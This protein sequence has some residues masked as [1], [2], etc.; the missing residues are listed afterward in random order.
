MLTSGRYCCYCTAHLRPYPTNHIF[1]F[2]PFAEPI[3]PNLALLLLLTAQLTEANA[4]TSHV[5]KDSGISSSIFKVW[6]MCKAR[7]GS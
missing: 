7:Y 3:L 4:S 6:I 2:G 1:V 5:Y